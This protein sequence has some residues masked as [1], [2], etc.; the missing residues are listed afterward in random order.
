V[1]RS[2]GYSPC[3]HRGDHPPRRH[4]FPAG[5]SYTH[6]EPRYLD[7]PTHSNGKVQKI[8]RTSSGRMVKCCIPKFY[9]INPSNELSTSSHPM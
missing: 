3:S 6:F 9:L 4:G 2:F 8:V 1:P 7:S 5:G